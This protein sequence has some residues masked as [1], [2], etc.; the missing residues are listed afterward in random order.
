MRSGK[1]TFLSLLVFLN[2]IAF[3]QQDKFK[4]WH[5]LDDKTD[6]LHGISIEKTYEILKNKKSKPVIVA[7][8]D[9]GVDT[10]QEDLKNVLWK[11]PKEIAGNGIDEDGNGYVDDVYGW[12]F[13]GGKDGRNI[14]TESAEA[15]RIYH[16]YKTKFANKQ[17][18]EAELS[19]NDKEQY[20]L[21]KQAAGII[22]AKPED[23]VELMFL[24]MAFKAV[25]KH[26]K[27]LRAEMKKDTFTIAEVE[28]FTPE[29]P[30]GQKAKLSYLT[31]MKLTGTES[32]E[33]NT[34]TFT[35]LEE[36]IEQK[37]KSV[38]A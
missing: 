19:G 7:V 13:L 5:L 22:K 18:N 3:G 15:T 34:N 6:T 16:R 24:E 14:K 1:F 38:A 28:K 17:I 10:T 27:V 23:E 12:N 33:T 30:E 21:W 29:L 9:S 25:K 8:I 35:Q 36:Y 4:G 31:F 11:N 37:K 2:T 32:E 26:E 20:E